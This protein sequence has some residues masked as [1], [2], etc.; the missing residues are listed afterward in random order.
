MN[1]VN[2]EIGKLLYEKQLFELQGNEMAADRIEKIIQI[3]RERNE[4]NAKSKDG[5]SN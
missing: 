5:A 2:K 1:A 3:I 4:L